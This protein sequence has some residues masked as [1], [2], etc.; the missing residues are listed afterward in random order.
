MGTRYKEL[1]VLNG[2]VIQHGHG[3][4]FTVVSSLS[5]DEP[6]IEDRASSEAEAEPL[7]RL[8]VAN[9]HLDNKLWP[10]IVEP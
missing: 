5:L 1:G 9:E 6:I 3:S 2:I 7:R 10:W 4:T 8:R